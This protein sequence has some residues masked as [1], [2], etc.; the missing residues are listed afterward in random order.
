MGTRWTSNTA[1]L[2]VQ[3]HPHACGDKYCSEHRNA[4]ILGSSPRVWGQVN[5]D[6]NTLNHRGIIPTRVWT[7]ISVCFV[8]M[9]F[10]DHPHACGDK[11]AGISY[12]FIMPGSSPRVWG[13]EDEIMEEIRV[14]RIIPTRVGTS[15]RL[16]I[17]YRR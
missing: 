5:S 12:G 13:Q 17:L 9:D 7:S 16:L 14:Y 6:R 8:A 15:L 2:G 3:D 10:E 1:S 11:T 4:G